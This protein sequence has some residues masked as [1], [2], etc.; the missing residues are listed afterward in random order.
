MV[1]LIPLGTDT[2]MEQVGP[3]LIQ[4]SEPITPSAGRV[5]TLVQAAEFEPTLYQY[6]NSSGVSFTPLIPRGFVE[7]LALYA[8][9][10]HD[11]SLGSVLVEFGHPKGLDT[12]VN[13]RL[14]DQYGRD[15]GDGWYFSDAPLTK[16]MFFN[17]PPG[18]YSVLVETK[19]RYWV[20]ADSIYA[21]SET[22]S[23]VNLGAQLRYRPQRKRSDDGN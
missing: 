21:Y 10:S 20:A 12:S 5:R 6:K 22:V 16:A 8:Q 4:T 3:G 18:I 15:V 11:S 13:M 14:L 1:D 9:V 17:V 19:D 7:D 23:Y 2:P